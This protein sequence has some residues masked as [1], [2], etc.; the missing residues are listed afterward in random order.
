MKKEWRKGNPCFECHDEVPCETCKAR[1]YYDIV[2]DTQKK[3]L[4]WQLNKV[5]DGGAI[6]RNDIEEM[7]A[8]LEPK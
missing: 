5:R 4:E 2:I 3:L 8:Q 7:I 1:M 6:F